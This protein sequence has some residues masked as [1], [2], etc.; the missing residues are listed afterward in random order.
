MVAATNTNILVS[1][2]FLT[3]YLATNT[4]PA[5]SN[6]ASI[7]AS[8]QIYGLTSSVPYMRLH[9]S[10]T[11]NLQVTQADATNWWC[12]TNGVLQRITNN[13]P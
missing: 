9:S 3:N 4:W 6:T 8:N 13:V 11:T 7:T 10:I 2:S 12:F 5:I 1:F